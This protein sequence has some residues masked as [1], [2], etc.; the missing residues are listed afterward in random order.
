MEEKQIRRRGKRRVKDR[1]NLLG[2]GGPFFCVKK[3]LRIMK[4]GIAFSSGFLYYMAVG[5][6]L[7]HLVDEKHH[8]VVF[9]GGKRVRHYFCSGKN[10][11]ERQAV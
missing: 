1:P 7:R 9:S 5:G 2:L 10:L 3:I 4:K 11:L 8:K 6:D